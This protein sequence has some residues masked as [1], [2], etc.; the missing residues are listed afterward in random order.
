MRLM[1]IKYPNNHKMKV[2]DYIEQELIIQNDGLTAWP[3]DTC[4]V[5]SG[6]QNQLQVFEEIQIGAVAPKNC[7]EVKIPI[8]MP[9]K[10]PY[11]QDRYIL[12]YELRHSYQTI[13]IG[14][15]MKL[16]ILIVNPDSSYKSSSRYDY[17]GGS[18]F[19]NPPLGSSEKSEE[20]KKQQI[21]V[22]E[23]AGSSLLSSLRESGS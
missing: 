16:S 17:G 10:F 1:S 18:S 9:D 15:P 22:R 6:N 21:N 13:L 11:N 14:V 2:N 4:F 20:E 8:K 23:S 19:N 12:E 3:Q 7:S 5:F